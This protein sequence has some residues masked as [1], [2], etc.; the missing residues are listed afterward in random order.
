[1]CTLASVDLYIIDT[2]SSHYVNCTNI[3]HSWHKSHVY[4]IPSE[5][6]LLIML[7]FAVCVLHFLFIMLLFVLVLSL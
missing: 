7:F 6:W 2:V 5:N 4:I 3:C 1:M